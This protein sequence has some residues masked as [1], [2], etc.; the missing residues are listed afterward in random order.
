M[1]ESDEI[2]R[3]EETA[4]IKEAPKKFKIKTRKS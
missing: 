3:G 4:F 1:S 2:P